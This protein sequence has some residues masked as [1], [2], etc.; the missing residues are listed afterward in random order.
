MSAHSARERRESAPPRSRRRAIFHRAAH[1]RS[2]MPGPRSIRQP[3]SGATNGNGPP[4]SRSPATAGCRSSR[5]A[6]RF[7]RAGVALSDVTGAK[8]PAAASER[9]TELAGQPFRAMGTSVRRASGQ[10]L[11]ADVARQRAPVHRARRRG[12]VVRRRLRPHAGLSIR[13][14][15][16]RAGTRRRAPPARPPASAPTHCSRTPATSTS[17]CR[18]AARRAA[19]AGC[20]PTTSTTSTPEIGGDFEHCFALIRRIGDAYLETYCAIVRRRADTP[21]GA[22]EQDFQRLRRG[23]YVEFNLAFDR[24]TRFGLQS[25][26]RTESLLMSLPPRAEWRYDYQPEPGSPE[27]RLAE[28][29][30][31]R[32]WLGGREDRRPAGEL[33]HARVARDARRARFPRGLAR[34][35]ARRGD[36][37]APVVA[38]AAR[39]HPARAAAR[40]RE[41]I[42]RHLDARRARRSR[43]RAR[44]CGAGSKRRCRS[45]GIPV[46]LAMLYTGGAKVP[47]GHR[48]VATAGADEIVVIPMFPQSCGATTGAVFDQVNAALRGLRD[49]PSL[50]FVSSYHDE[51]ALHRR[52]RRERAR[53]T[54]ASTAPRATC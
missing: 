17:G 22:R 8:L 21:F 10:S 35:S 27:A 52:A 30:K 45:D 34:R 33:R 3:R 23:R 20:S 1:A 26:A 48:C 11:R 18:I 29:L 41:E 50:R 51:P 12:V 54:A 25:Q 19:S 49:V 4:G 36:S 6:R 24:G 13:R 9:H 53:I 42:R 32:D 39:H 47:R 2:A 40:Q 46:A 15:R 38:D 43:S 5:T 7:D 16:A 44:R 14:G 28:Y 31:P 37:A